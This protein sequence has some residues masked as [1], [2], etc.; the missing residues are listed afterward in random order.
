[1]VPLYSCQNFRFRWSCTHT[2]T[3]YKQYTNS[4]DISSA[5]GDRTER[6]W[7]LHCEACTLL[8]KRPLA[9]PTGCISHS[10]PYAM[11]DCS[12]PSIIHSLREHTRSHP[13]HAHITWQTEK[14][15]FYSLEL[16]CHCCTRVNFSTEFQLFVICHCGTRRQYN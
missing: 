8:S 6:E 2:H 10:H 5:S 4:I 9:H 13:A 15:C 14:N 7:A 11:C 16:I 12:L 1:M 3:H